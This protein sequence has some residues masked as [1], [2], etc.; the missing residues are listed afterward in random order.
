[1]S[2]IVLLGD[3]MIG[4]TEGIFSTATDILPDEGTSLL[5]PWVSLL[6]GNLLATCS[7]WTLEEATF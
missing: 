6:E 4:D 5:L 7:G 2:A 3:F 1:M